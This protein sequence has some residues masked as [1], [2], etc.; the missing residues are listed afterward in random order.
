MWFTFI[1]EPAANIEAS[2]G[3]LAS[4]HPAVARR[5]EETQAAALAGETAHLRLSLPPFRVDDVLKDCLCSETNRS[6]FRFKLRVS[7]RICSQQTQTTT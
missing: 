1:D 4:E 5:G 7:C 3:P 6:V 2:V